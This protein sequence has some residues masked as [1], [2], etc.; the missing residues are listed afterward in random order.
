MTVY[1]LAIGFAGAVVEPEKIQNIFPSGCG[2]ARYAPNCWIISTNE[3]AAQLVARMRTLISVSDSVFAVEIDLKNSHG[4]L[5][6]E[7]WGYIKGFG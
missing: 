1:H 5:Q 3:S 6:T 7:I 4:Y 2:W